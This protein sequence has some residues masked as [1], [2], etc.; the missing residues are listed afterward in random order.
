MNYALR[1]RDRDKVAGHFRSIGGSGWLF[2]VA[3]IAK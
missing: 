3:G 2:K 1:D